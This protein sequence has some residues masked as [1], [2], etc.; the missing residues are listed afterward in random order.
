MI[1]ERFRKWSRTSPSLACVR[2][3]GSREQGEE[4]GRDLAEPASILNS[5]VLAA[6][7]LTALPRTSMHALAP[8]AGVIA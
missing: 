8:L 7:A 2:G 4:Q 6:P 1:R 3:S 5:L